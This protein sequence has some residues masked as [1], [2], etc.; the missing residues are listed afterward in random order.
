VDK[1]K[2][3]RIR[4]WQ[5][6][7]FYARLVMR[8]LAIVVMLVIA[9]WK[10]LT[11]NIVTT[12]ANIAKLAG[13]ALIAID[14]REHAVAGVVLL[15]L[16]LLLDHLDGTIARYRRCGTQFGAFYDK[17]SDAI[18]WGIIMVALGWA[19]YRDTANVWLPIAAIMSAYALLV[20]GYMKWIVVAASPR[21]A[22]KPAVHA[23]PER[24]AA[25]W[26][27]W[28]VSSLARAALFEEV[29]LFFWIGV[30]VL[31]GRIDLLIWLLAITQGAQ[32]VV[33]LVRR[34]LQ[35]YR[36]DSVSRRDGDVD[37][38]EREVR[39]AD[40][41]REPEGNQRQTDKAADAKHEA[42]EVA[43][44]ERARDAERRRVVLENLG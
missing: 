44:A 36:L 32:L 37:D 7:E 38:R 6:S 1:H 16:G 22:S 12:L 28:F 33:M 15:Q 41:D 20:L 43:A 42:V 35:V 29:D 5:S 8:P 18:T 2:L 27:R 11:P 3:Q 39:D 17:V 40:R 14:H 21:V 13:A 9:D 31:V 4:N 30:G 23:V 19:A 34:A 24:S 25:D 10:W 26:A